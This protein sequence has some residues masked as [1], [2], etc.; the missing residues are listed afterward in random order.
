MSQEYPERGSD[1][2]KEQT[3]RGSDGKREQSRAIEGN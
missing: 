3:R 1:K 2:K